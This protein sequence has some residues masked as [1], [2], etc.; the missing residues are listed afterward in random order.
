MS[1]SRIMLGSPADGADE[2]AL[3]VSE[4]QIR[5]AVAQTAAA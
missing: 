5:N 1:E 4:A 2:V 3:P